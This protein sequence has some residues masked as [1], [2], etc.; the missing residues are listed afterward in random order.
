MIS[1]DQLSEFYRGYFVGSDGKCFSNKSGKM[2]ILKTYNSGKGYRVIKPYINGK[3]I[4]MYIH[5]LVAVAF[6]FNEFD[7]PFVNHIDGDKTNND[8]VNLEW[9]THKE[10]M[11][12]ASSTGLM[13]NNKRSKPVIC[14]LNGVGK[15]FPST[16]E[17][18]RLGF[19]SECI[20]RVCLGR[21]AT[22]RGLHWEHC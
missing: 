3:N 13:N 17:A 2:L 11:A 19:T 15:W 7:K 20:S 14:Y 6:V 9:V 18:Q 21:N 22:H 16:M 1:D 8:V 12:H 5:R 4:N 10:N